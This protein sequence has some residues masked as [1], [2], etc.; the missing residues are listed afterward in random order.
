MIHSF[1]LVGQSNMAGRGFINDAVPVNSD[2]I[3]TLRNGHWYP[4]FRPICPDKETAGGSLAE[5]FAELNGYSVKE[6]AQ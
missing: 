6:D 4:M 1:L 5:R 2:N 3:V